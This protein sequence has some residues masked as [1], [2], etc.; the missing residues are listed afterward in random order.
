MS[1]SAKAA[2]GKPSKKAPSSQAG[3]KWNERISGTTAVVTL[4]G[5]I[6]AAII[7]SVTIYHYVFEPRA[8]LSADIERVTVQQDVTF[9]HYEEISG[10]IGN[11]PSALVPPRNTQGILVQVQAQLSGYGPHIYS[12]DLTLLSAK[13]HVQLTDLT[14]RIYVCTQAVPSAVTY[15]FVLQ[16]WTGE[17]MSR[18]RFI[19]RTRLY[20]SGLNVSKSKGYVP[21]NPRY[22]AVLDAGVFT[23]T[24]S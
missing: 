21:V 18:Q 1:D 14:S 3:P 11:P 16:C 5:S 12:G 10:A 19:V 9:G 23:S 6:L 13:T 8:E 24:S 2:S 15:G 20:D 22:L 4:I 7:S 17:P